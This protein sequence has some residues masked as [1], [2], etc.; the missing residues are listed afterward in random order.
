MT[1]STN[2]TPTTAKVTQNGSINPVNGSRCQIASLEVYRGRAQAINI[3]YGGLSLDDN[4]D[5]MVHVNQFEE[6]SII[7][8]LHFLDTHR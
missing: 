6:C 8:E 4:G 3:S 7:F 5:L 1:Y 2:N